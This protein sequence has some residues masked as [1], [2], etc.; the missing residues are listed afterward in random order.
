M[1]IDAAAEYVELEVGQ[2]AQAHGDRRQVALE[3]AR[4]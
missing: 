4:V 3:E 1:Q 2:A